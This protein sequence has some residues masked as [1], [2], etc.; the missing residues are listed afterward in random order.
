MRNVLTIA[1]VTAILKS[2]LENSLIQQAVNTGMGDVSITTLPPDRIVTGAEERPQLNLYLYRLTPDTG[3]RRA[4]SDSVHRAP[5]EQELTLNLHY[6]LS[7]YGERDFQS[8]MLLGVALECLQTFASLEGERLHTTLDTLMSRKS[9]NV[10]LTTLLRSAGPARLEQLKVT[11]EFLNLEELSKLW[12][13]FQA[14]ARLSITYQVSASLNFA[15][16]HEGAKSAQVL[17]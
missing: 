4:A 11:P 5:G 6:L 15:D 8:E 9:N 3:W 14:R 13:S 7:A 10:T 2:L 17:R 12:G 1:V 16:N